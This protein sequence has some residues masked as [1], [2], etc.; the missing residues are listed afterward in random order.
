MKS[1]PQH[2]RQ[3]NKQALTDKRGSKK[4]VLCRCSVIHLKR[5]FLNF[6][7]FFFFTSTC[8]AGS[9][10]AHSLASVGLKIQV[11]QATLESSHKKRP[12]PFFPI[13]NTN[14]TGLR[15]LLCTLTNY[16]TLDHCCFWWASVPSIKKF[17]RVQ[18]SPWLISHTDN[19]KKCINILGPKCLTTLASVG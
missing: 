6:C 5:V 16:L 14:K 15:H 19:K 4:A 1:N 18:R 9:C 8:P 7:F 12:A 11:G 2:R 17:H 10:V 13:L 3:V